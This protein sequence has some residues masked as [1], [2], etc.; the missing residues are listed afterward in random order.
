MD[1]LPDH[2]KQLEDLKLFTED[3]DK[4]LN[5][6]TSFL[7][8]SVDSLSDFTPPITC[9]FDNAHHL[10]EKKLKD[11]LEKCQWK[12]EGYAETDLPL[13]WPTLPEN[14]PFCIQITENLQDEILKSAKLNNPSNYYFLTLTTG[15]GNRLIPRT[16]DRLIADFTPDERRAL[17]EYYL[18]NTVQPDIGEDIA[19]LNKPKKTEEKRTSYLE[20]LAHERDLKRRRAKH[21]GVH[22]NK[23]SQTEILREVI[24]QQMEMLT[25][26]IAEK[27]HNGAAEVKTKGV[28]VER[29]DTDELRIKESHRERRRD[30]FDRHRSHRSDS[31]RETSRHRDDD[32][33][34]YSNSR[35]DIKTDTDNGRSGSR[36]RDYDS[37]SKYHKRED[38]HRHRHHSDELN[39][40]HRSD[41]YSKHEKRERHRSRD[42]D[43]D[44]KSYKKYK[45]D[46]EKHENDGDKYKYDK[47]SHRRH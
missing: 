23:K 18:A 25:E 1:D 29:V 10:S 6:V 15:T 20:L 41:K 37:H 2:N 27:N 32:R 7:G 30:D 24:N 16:S 28:K 19:D 42:R 8:W 46:D 31:S 40:P 44:H 33:H 17:Y 47:K 11:H 21:R 4:K 26:Y 34:K 22:T 38:R 9:P 35:R 39:H 3:V 13:S 43:S 5:E 14:S 45:Y 12:A 36:H